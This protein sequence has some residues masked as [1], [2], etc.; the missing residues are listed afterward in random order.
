MKVLAPEDKPLELQK[1]LLAAKVKWNDTVK[2][3]YFMF[4]LNDEGSKRL[5]QVN[6]FL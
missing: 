2:K 5:T 4:Q 1:K 3:N 6:S